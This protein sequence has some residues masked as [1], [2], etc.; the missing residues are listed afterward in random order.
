MEPYKVT[1][2][3]ATIPTQPNRYLGTPGKVHVVGYAQVKKGTGA[4][5]QIRKNIRRLI[6]DRPDWELT[7]VNTDYLEPES[8]K[9]FLCLCRGIRDKYIDVLIIHSV[10][11]LKSA[12]NLTYWLL[13]HCKM[14]GVKLYIAHNDALLSEE[15]FRHEN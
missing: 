15:D 9:T 4:G 6:K 12:I 5:V 3:P 11:D 1:K 10:G 13:Q 7:F 14:F 8:W 2:I